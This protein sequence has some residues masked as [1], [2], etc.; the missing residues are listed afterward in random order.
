[1]S[2][3]AGLSTVS[4]LVKQTSLLNNR[5]YVSAKEG[6]EFAETAIRTTR[7]TYSSQQNKLDNSFSIGTLSKDDYDKQTNR[8]KHQVEIDC[9]PW[10]IY[11]KKL[12]QLIE[13][14]PS[15]SETQQ[16]NKRTFNQSSSMKKPHSNLSVSKR[17]RITFS[18]SSS[19]SD[20]LEPIPPTTQ[21]KSNPIIIKHDSSTNTSPLELSLCSPFS[22]TPNTIPFTAQTNYITQRIPLQHINE[23]A[24]KQIVLLH[25]EGQLVRWNDVI[26]RILTYFH[27]QDLGNIG[28]QRADQIACIDNLIRTQNKINIYVDSYGYWQT[29]GTLNELE[30][31]LARIFYK[32]DYNELLLGPIERQ[33]KIEELFRL[34]HIRNEYIKKDLKTSDVLKYLDQYMTKESVWKTENE[35]NVE[36]FFKF[37]AKQIHVKDIYQLGIRMKSAYLARNCIKT[38]QANQRKTMEIARTELNYILT[39]LVQKEIENISKIINDKLDNNN[40]QR[41]IYASMDP[42]DIINDLIDFDDK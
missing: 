10:E 6:L 20:T 38:M 9:A 29:I 19:D 33:P 42:I 35:I 37:I 5:Q 18:S 17:S 8:L 16:N 12:T 25:D 11:V 40:Q 4:Q 14:Y 30:N 41:K 34:K 31:D 3:S 22:S 27:V 32:N 2:N 36:H 24:A 7:S 15:Q 39:D 13:H 28:V 1:M 21:K 26:W 23:I